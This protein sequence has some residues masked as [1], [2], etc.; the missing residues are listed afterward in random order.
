M[1]RVIVIIL[2]ALTFAAGAMYRYPLLISLGFAEIAL[3]VTLALIARAALRSADFGF[4]AD[5]AE[6]KV[7][8]HVEVPVTA[9]LKKSQ[10]QR[11]LFVFGLSY[12][13]QKTRTRRKVLCSAAHGANTIHLGF[14]PNKCGI[15]LVTLRK[16]R[17]YDTL[18]L[19]WSSRKVDTTMRVVVL[20]E[21]A[22]QDPY[23]AEQAFLREGERPTGIRGRAGETVSIRE[24]QDGDMAKDVHWKRTAM[25]GDLWVREN[26]IPRGGEIFLELDWDF[27]RDEKAD[28]A[29]KNEYYGKLAGICSA[30]IEDGSA[31]TVLLPG[32]ESGFRIENAEDM[33]DLFLE[34]YTAAACGDTAAARGGAAAVLGNAEYSGMIGADADLNVM[35]LTRDLKVTE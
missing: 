23:E 32:K 31:V 34:V 11:A 3:P 4:G 17:F 6:A 14:T 21:A 2:I 10:A 33:Y 18:G 35:R 5:S 19:F 15:V 8:T 29:K 24:Y 16:V 27:L 30:C 9:N 26:V 12:M 13:G 20:P 1:K 25:T 28:A 7:K 22:Y